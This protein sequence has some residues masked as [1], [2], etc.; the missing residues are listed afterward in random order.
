MGMG[1]VGQTGDVGDLAGGV[2][3]RFT[4]QRPGAAVDGPIDAVE[5]LVAAQPRLDAQ[6]RQGMGKQVVGAAVE[7]GGADDV[8]ASSRPASGWHR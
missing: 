6:L 7:F 2:A 8:V 3:D 5:I 4:E 1:D